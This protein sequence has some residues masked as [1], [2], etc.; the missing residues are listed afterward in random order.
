MDVPICEIKDRVVMINMEH[1]LRTKILWWCVLLSYEV[2]TMLRAVK[3]R[4]VFGKF[5]KSLNSYNWEAK[6]SEK[7]NI[8]SAVLIFLVENH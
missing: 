3:E 5:I 2:Y 4:N 1:E 8:C 7:D 6:A